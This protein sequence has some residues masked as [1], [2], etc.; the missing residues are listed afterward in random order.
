M[1]GPDPGDFQL[2]GDLLQ[3][4]LEVFARLHEVLDVVDVGEVRLELVEEVG[5]SLGQVLVGQQVDEVTEVVARVERQPPDLKNHTKVAL[6]LVNFCN[7]DYKMHVLT[8][9]A[10]SLHLRQNSFNVKLKFNG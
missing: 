9:Q 1:L 10:F 4:A 3:A 8:A 2:V 5:F 6:T 7:F